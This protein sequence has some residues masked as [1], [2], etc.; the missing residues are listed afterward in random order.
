MALWAGGLRPDNCTPTN[1]EAL[2]K[3]WT[4][5][6]FVRK[7]GHLTNVQTRLK[8]VFRTGHNGPIQ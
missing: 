4:T 2:T 6:D 8:N 5:L 1:W 3:C 7:H